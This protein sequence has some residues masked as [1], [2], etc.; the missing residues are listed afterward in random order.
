MDRLD[1]TGDPR[2][3]KAAEP[4]GR[5]SLM[6]P[7]AECSYHHQ[8]DQSGH[9]QGSACLMLRCFRHHETNDG[10]KPRG[11]ILLA[12][13]DSGWQGQG[14]STT[15]VGV[16]P[17]A[18]VDDCRGCA[19][20]HKTHFPWAVRQQEKLVRSH[21]HRLTAV[22]VDCELSFLDHDNVRHLRVQLDRV[23]RRE[24]RGLYFVPGETKLGEYMRK[25]ISRRRG[26]FLVVRMNR[27]VSRMPCHGS[28]SRREVYLCG[29]DAHSQSQ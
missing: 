3:D 20:R 27:Q 21:L 29:A 1:G 25:Q 15:A 18:A 22:C 8:I 24:R 14:R 4:A 13:V 26:A 17:K 12:D 16:E 28:L 23:T 2:V 6:D 9:H 19:G 7:T 5:V 10:L 11:A